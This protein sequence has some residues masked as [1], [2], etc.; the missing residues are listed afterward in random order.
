MKIERAREL[1][2][3]YLAEQRS[4]GMKKAEFRNGELLSKPKRWKLVYTIPK[5]GFLIITIMAKS[6]KLVA[7]KEDRIRCLTDGITFPNYEEYEKHFKGLSQKEREE[8]F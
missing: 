7:E 3:L 2:S 5:G 4:K 6:T 1:A 8:H